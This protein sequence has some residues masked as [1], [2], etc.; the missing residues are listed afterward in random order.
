MYMYT[1]ICICIYMYSVTSE[2]FKSSGRRISSFKDLSALTVQTC[3][4]STR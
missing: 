4:C 3:S 1:R 2:Q